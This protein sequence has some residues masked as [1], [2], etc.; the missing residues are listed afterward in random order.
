[1]AKATLTEPLMGGT[2]HREQERLEK[3]A[4]GDGVRRYWKRV[5]LAVK[6]GDAASLK[7]VERLVQHWFEPTRVLLDDALAKSRQGKGPYV[8]VMLGIVDQL[9]RDAVVSSTMQQVLGAMVESNYNVKLARVC[10][11]VGRA[12]VA[13]YNWKMMKE[14]D[15]EVGDAILTKI[16][17][18]YKNISPIIVNWWRNKHLGTLETQQS[19]SIRI[20]SMMFSLLRD[21][22]STGDY[23]ED[24]FRDAFIIESVPHYRNNKPATVKMVRLSDEA[25]RAIDEGHELR[26]Y[27]RPVYLPMVTKP[28]RWSENAQG[29]YIRIRTPFVANISEEQRQDFEQADLSQV[30]Q[31]LDDLTATPFRINR[32]ILD[33]MDRLF[34]EGGGLACVPESQPLPLP[35]RLPETATEEE[36]KLNKTQRKVIYNENIKRAAAVTDFSTMTAQAKMFVGYD[37]MWIP[38]KFDF[39][40]RVNALPAHL[41]HQ[42]RDYCR[43]LFE[44]AEPCPATSDRAKWWLKI[45]AA[46][47]WANEGLDKMPFAV[48]AEWVDA[49]MRRIRRASSDPLG[50]DWWMQADGGEKPWQFLAACRA[51]CDDEAGARIPVQMDGTCNGL[52]HY[53]AIMRDIETAGHVN[54][55]PDEQPNDIYAM[56]ADA[57]KRL[58]AQDAR[59][60]NEVAKMV[61]GLVDRKLCKQPTMTIVYGSTMIGRTNQVA[62]TIAGRVP[63]DDIGKCSRY[64]S[65]VVERSIMS[66]APGAWSAMA[67]L[68][69]VASEVCKTGKTIRWTTP[70]GFPVRQS[71]R[72]SSKKTPSVIRLPFG[73]SITVRRMPEQCDPVAKGKAKNAFAP[74]WVHSL[75]A[76]HLMMTGMRCAA[77]SMS[78]ADVH[79]SYWSHAARTDDMHRHIREQFVALHAVDQLKRLSDEIEQRYDIELPDTPDRGDLDLKD[80]LNSPYFFM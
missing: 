56:V 39:R 1:M 60:G 14:H 7:P 74:N 31:A 61:D 62:G 18:T 21:A 78:F 34:R 45:H 80:V 40:G 59:S 26:K 57:A 37:K 66:M 17:R 5:D 46:N 23:L 29:G 30:Y 70:L 38:R 28:H 2:L 63:P 24:E 3:M 13:L 35:P 48:R 11:R 10:Y 36:I 52:Q 8:D 64:L 53:A 33:T 25:R 4:V 32:F 68:R 79:D 54:L 41:N 9:D 27:L 20:G 58:V 16:R 44:F 6:R 55:L 69:E 67:W 47:C 75:D 65:A 71:Y 50:D 43:G 76:A 49:N 51:L 19:V 15:A 42:R 12:V 22:A 77:D 72:K 73:G